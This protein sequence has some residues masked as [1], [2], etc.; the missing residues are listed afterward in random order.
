M[1]SIV[2]Y[3]HTLFCDDVRHEVNGKV[4][5]IGVFAG[6][7]KL[8]EAP[9]GQPNLPLFQMVMHYFEPLEYTDKAVT[10]EVKVS[11]DPEFE[12][13]GTLL[14]E[15]SRPKVPVPTMGKPPFYLTSNFIVPIPPLR[16][17]EECVLSCTIFI[18][19]DSI[20]GGSLWLQL[21]RENDEDRTLI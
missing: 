19:E 13:V 16:I 11:C 2:P 5:F 20:K 9:D 4:S 8:L 6:P 1:T 18:G 21:E 17:I 7:L 3:A 14:D 15:G 12:I 10:F